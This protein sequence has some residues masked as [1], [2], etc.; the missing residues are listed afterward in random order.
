MEN[1]LRVGVITS[2]HGIKGEVKVY[3]TTE[4]PQRFRQL[5][6]VILDTGK[7]L[8]PLDI[9]EV[10]FFKQM[11]ILKFRGIDNINDV[12]K[13]RNMD[14]LVTRENAIKLEEG[15]YFI[16]DLINCEVF[17]ESGERLGILTEVMTNAANDVYVVQMDNGKEVLLPAINDCI[18]NIDV[19]NKKVIV[20]LMKGLL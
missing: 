3:P 11:V 14:L 12:Q 5:E 2:T 9:E 8:I 19:E 4:D 16:C 20:H 17:T 10:K 7:E 1:Y 6:Q 18:L 13:Y 15:E